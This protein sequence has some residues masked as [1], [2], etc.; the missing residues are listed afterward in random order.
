MQLFQCD[1]A[2]AQEDTKV[3]GDEKKTSVR[4]CEEGQGQFGKEEHWG[5]EKARSNGYRQGASFF[6]K[7]LFLVKTFSVF[8]K[9]RSILLP[10]GDLPTQEHLNV[11][12]FVSEPWQLCSQD[13]KVTWVL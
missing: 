1:S 6:F 5:V 13:S 7:I 8:C 2:T 4:N 10:A 3:D 9:G 12:F 11:K